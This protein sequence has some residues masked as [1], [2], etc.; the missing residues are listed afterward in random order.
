VHPV[1][2]RSLA[3]SGR[4]LDGVPIQGHRHNSPKKSSPAMSKNGPN[5]GLQGCRRPTP[6]AGPATRCTGAHP[7]S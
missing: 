5:A 7:C 2:R 3:A 1:Q 6:H 4:L